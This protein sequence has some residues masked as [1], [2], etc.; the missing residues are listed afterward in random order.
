MRRRYNFRLVRVVNKNNNNICVF[1]IYAINL[2]KYVLIAMS[3]YSSG[4]PLKKLRQTVLSFGV[5]KAVKDAGKLLKMFLAYTCAHY[6][7]CREQAVIAVSCRIHL[8]CCV[9]YIIALALTTCLG[10]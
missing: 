1:L 8:R 4:P 2:T 3:S 6:A 5:G 9:L 10:L 7:D